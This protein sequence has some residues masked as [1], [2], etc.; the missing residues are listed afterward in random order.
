MRSTVRIVFDALDDGRNAILVVATEVDQTIVL[1]VTTTDV[2]G[3]DATVVVTTTGLALL[4]D[5]RSIRSALVQVLALT[6]LTTKR[7]PA[8]VGLHLTIAM[9]HSY[10]TQH[11][12]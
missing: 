2:T 5:Q 12:W 6:T 7:R 11:C 10:L 3:G 8:E 4:L 9:M 1:L